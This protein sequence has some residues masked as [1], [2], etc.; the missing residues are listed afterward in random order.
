MKIFLDTVC[1]KQVAQKRETGLIDGLTTN[2][3]LLAKRGDPPLEVLRS[4]CALEV[5]PISIEVTEDTAEAMVAQAK[6]FVSLSR[7][8]VIKVP[9]TQEGLKACVLLRKQSIA[10][11]VT[12]C[13]S[14]V[15]AI[16][17]AKA[18]A[19]Y[20]SPFVGR[21][22]DT[23]ESA[24]DLLQEIR[25]C[26]DAYQYRTQILAASIRSPKQVL[27][28]CKAR[29]DAVTM[30]PHVFEQLYLHPLTDQGL[31]LFHQDWIALMRDH[32]N[33]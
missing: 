32:T 8:V 21:I 16:L 9:L 3:S 27:Q 15:Q 11:N 4:L 33:I 7:H 24:E 25:G 19:T 18:G 1:E 26:Y 20:V 22:E 13:F 23:G 12:L 5:G 10:V 14:V 30:P 2:P 28:A 29:V 6:D 17:A 31:S